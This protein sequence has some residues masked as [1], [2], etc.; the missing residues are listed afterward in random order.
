MNMYD[1]QQAMQQFALQQHVFAARGSGEGTSPSSS[2]HSCT[3]STKYAVN[4]RYA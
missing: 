2:R 1:D 3:K 4:I